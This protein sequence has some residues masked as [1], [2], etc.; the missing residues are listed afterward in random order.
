MGEL[1]N[2]LRW[3]GAP[4]TLL[5]LAVLALND[6]VL[7]QAAPGV[8]TGK[9]SDLAGLVLTP[10]LLAVVLAVLRVPRAAPV[11]LVATAVAFTVV[12][13]TV[14]GVEAANAVWSWVGWPTQILRDPTDLLALPALLLAA[15]VSRS[16]RRRVPGAR[17]RVG[18]ALGALAL[19]FPVVATA[20][21]SPCYTAPGLDD[22]GVVRGDWS[23]PP[24]GAENRLVVPLSYR[25]VSIDADGRLRTLSKVDDAAWPT[26]AHASRRPAPSPSRAGAGAALP[27]RRNRGSRPRPTVAPRGAPTT[28][29]RHGS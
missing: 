19:P 20:A 23:G 4:P 11:A 5:A 22:V 21:T 27:G 28:A 15:L 26:S 29:C 25:P 12:K 2:A 14:S 24:T 8:V 6:H 13:T 17:H 18:L 1:K 7:K 3:L 16:E 10:A 9:L